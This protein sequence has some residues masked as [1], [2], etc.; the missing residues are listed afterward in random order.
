MAYRLE[1]VRSATREIEAVARKTDRRKIVERIASLGT[2]PRP[3]GC[4]K[5]AGRDAYRVRQGDCRI[6]YTIDDAAR[7]V[8][9]VRVAH[10]SAKVLDP[11]VHI[12]R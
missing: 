8:A 5:L 6:L 4:S 1:I 11:H 7:I 2:D 9:V 3:P 12:P 10:T